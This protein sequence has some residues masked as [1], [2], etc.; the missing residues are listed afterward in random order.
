MRISGLVERPLEQIPQTCPVSIC[1]CLRVRLRCL[2]QTAAQDKATTAAVASAEGLEELAE[3]SVPELDGA[4]NASK[5]YYP[6]MYFV[7]KELACRPACVSS[8]ARTIASVAPCAD[9]AN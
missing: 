6:A 3:K 8:S 2:L 4:V 5:L 7:D 9:E 1:A